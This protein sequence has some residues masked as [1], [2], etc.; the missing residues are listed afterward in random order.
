[1]KKKT[2]NEF[3]DIAAALGQIPWNIKEATGILMSFANGEMF[4]QDGYVYKDNKKIKKWF[5]HREGW[6]HFWEPTLRQIARI[7]HL[8]QK[9]VL[10]AQK[11]WDKLSE[12]LKL[13]AGP[14]DRNYGDRCT[15]HFCIKKEGKTDWGYYD[16]G[17]NTEFNCLSFSFNWLKEKPTPVMKLKLGNALFKTE[18]DRSRWQYQLGG[19]LEDAIMNKLR[20]DFPNLTYKNSGEVFELMIN[21]RKYL[22]VYKF[23]ERHSYGFEKLAWPEN[24]TYNRMVFS[25]EQAQP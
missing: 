1:M 3:Q 24:K 21:C 6:N 15:A 11:R 22:Y 20:T 19:L 12:V 16:V 13:I 5:S 2:K 23:P 4:G 17:F 18:R 7:E 8:Y 25:Y 14:F 9:A 10:K